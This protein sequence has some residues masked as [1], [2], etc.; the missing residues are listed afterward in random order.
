MDWISQYFLKDQFPTNWYI[1]STKFQSNR[2]ICRNWIVDI[3][4]LIQN[5]HGNTKDFEF[6]KQFYERKIKLK[7]MLH[8]LRFSVKR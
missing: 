4:G 7:D 1:L 6:P 5:L 3:E 8:N 2:R